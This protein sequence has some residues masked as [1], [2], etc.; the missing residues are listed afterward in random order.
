[1]SATQR[2][3][4]VRFISKE[5]WKDD[6]KHVGPNGLTVWAMTKTTG[7]VKARPV[8]TVADAVTLALN[9]P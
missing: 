8:A 7:N 4:L 9:L 5:K 3:V 6:V 2:K 1:M